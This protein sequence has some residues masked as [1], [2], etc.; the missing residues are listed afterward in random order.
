MDADE[1][2]RTE[3]ASANISRMKEAVEADAAAIEAAARPSSGR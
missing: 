1:R 2:R 3:A